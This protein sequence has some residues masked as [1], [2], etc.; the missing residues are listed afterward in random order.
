METLTPSSK[1]V[2]WHYQHKVIPN[3]DIPV[4]TSYQRE[5]FKRLY[6]ELL[7]MWALVEAYTGI[8]WKATSLLR[9]KDGPSHKDA[10]ALDIA[11]DIAPSAYKYYAVYK[12]S[13]P[14]LY[15]RGPL[16]RQLQRLVG[17]EF[18]NVPF[19]IAF[20]VESDHIHI[21]V[22]ELESQQTTGRLFLIKWKQP[23]PIYNDT[24]ARMRLP[25][26]W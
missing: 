17:N 2:L 13:D 23:K 5:R 8:A 9:S 22:F 14:V 24:Y 15:K 21:G 12:R 4:L 16:L 1:Q 19:N 3:Q 25:M 11:P 10:T 18:P 7:R 20:V 6:P 26:F